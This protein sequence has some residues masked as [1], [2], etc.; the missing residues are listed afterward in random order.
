MLEKWAAK[1]IILFKHCVP[2]ASQY[3][4]KQEVHLNTFSEI[5]ELK[6]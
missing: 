1:R 5:A 6:T 3:Q 4:G 2:R